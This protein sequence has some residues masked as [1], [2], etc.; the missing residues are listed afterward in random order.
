MNRIFFLK[1]KW[2]K[3]V[4]N[5]VISKKRKQFLFLCSHHFV[6]TTTSAS[7]FFY[8][9]C[10]EWFYPNLFMIGMTS[11]YLTN[12]VFKCSC[13]QAYTYG[14]TFFF[15]FSFIL[16]LWYFEIIHVVRYINYVIGY[17][18]CNKETQNYSESYKIKVY[19]SL[20]CIPDQRWASDSEWE[21][22][23]PHRII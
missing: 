11:I 4:Y 19:L 12:Y 22:A 16:Q 9:S 21:E 23:L 17:N 20:Y 7:T 1:N 10:T 18:C 2:I 5:K 15:Y 14:N 8:R 6:P 13:S 3:Y